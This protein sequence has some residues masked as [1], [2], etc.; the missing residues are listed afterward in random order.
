MNADQAHAAAQLVGQQL[1]TEWKTTYKVLTALPE[2]KKD[3]K[4]EEHSRAAFEL[5]KHL[6]AADVWF[7][8][9]VING[10]FDSPSEPG[11]STVAELGDWYKQH[12]PRTLERALALEG[13][14]LAQTVDFFGMKL[15]AVNY[16]LFAL[17][18]MVHHRGQ[19]ST[20]LR[21][22]GGK[23]PSIYGGSYDEP[24]TGVQDVSA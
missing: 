14:Q 22:C 15:P 16:L 9:G 18:H 19:L 17:V 23:V 2:N 10:R 7:L 20:Y 12:F 4:P 24:W 21:P 13:P 8:E 6:A 11:A 5:A 1:Q 3:F